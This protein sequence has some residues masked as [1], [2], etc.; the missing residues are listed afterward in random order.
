M[1]TVGKAWMA[2]LISWIPGMKHPST[3]KTQFKNCHEYDRVRMVLKAR[4]KICD[5][6]VSRDAELA[7]ELVFVC[8]DTDCGCKKIYGA[9][10]HPVC[11]LCF[12]MFQ[13]LYVNYGMA[14]RNYFKDMD[15]REKKEFND[16]EKRKRMGL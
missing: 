8:K 3:T 2:A 13:A 7:R 16:P 15:D 11:T 1:I 12:D 10:S 4:C 6:T 14:Y 9:I 5:A